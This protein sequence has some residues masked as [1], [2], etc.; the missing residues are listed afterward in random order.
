MTFL[1]RILLATL[2]SALFSVLAA[3]PAAFAQEE[4]PRASGVGELEPPAVTAAQAE[5]DPSKLGDFARE[6]SRATT[7]ATDINGVSYIGCLFRLRGGPFFSGSTYTITIT[8][9]PDGRVWVNTNDMSTAGRQ[10]EPAIYRE[11]LRSLGIDVTSLATITTGLRSVYNTK[12]F[13]SPEGGAF[14]AGSGASGYAV[15]YVA[16]LSGIPSILLAGF[17]LKPSHL[18]PETIDHA[19]PEITAAQVTDRATLKQFVNGAADFAKTIAESRDPSA[20][21]KVRVAFRDPNGP[22]RHGPTYLFIMDDTGYTV[23]HG[24]FPDRFELQAPTETLRDERTGEL[25]LPQIIQTAMRAGEAGDYV[26]YHFDDPHDPT[27]NFN[28]RKVS[29]VRQYTAKVGGR[30]VTF[31]IGAGI[32]GEETGGMA[33]DSCP[34]GPGVAELPPPSVT[35]AQAEAD[36]S[37]LGEFALAALSATTAT[38]RNIDEA[39]YIACLFRLRGG[40][41]FPAPPIPSP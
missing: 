41:S 13:P 7:A 25:I 16:P 10:L 32:Y 36:P 28:T 34:R 2:I 19:M 3:A 11:I 29:Y 8:L 14:D 27:D 24:A 21:S 9:T 22:W 5:A 6:A 20:A 18:A 12:T 31:I 15:G 39:S 23:F 17:D 40:L 33:Q 1:K 30:D 35:A 38:T 4:C 26:E 37:K